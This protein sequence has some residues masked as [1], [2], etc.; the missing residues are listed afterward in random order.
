MRLLSW[1]V[2]VSLAAAV[3]AVLWAFEI[4]GIDLE[5]DE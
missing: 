4:L 3:L 2:D 1:I 5:L